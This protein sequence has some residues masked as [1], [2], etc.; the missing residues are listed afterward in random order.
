[1]P[2]NF[3]PISILTTVCCLTLCLA[4][5]AA[6]IAW[7]AFSS[8]RRQNAVIAAWE[9]LAVR[10]R[11]KLERIGLAK[12]PLFSG[13]Y[14]NRQLILNYGM[15][16][17]P[18]DSNSRRL[19]TTIQLEVNVPGSNWLSVRKLGLAE[20]VTKALSVQATPTGEADFDRQFLVVSQPKE[21]AMQLLGSDP[22]ARTILASLNSEPFGVTLY[23]QS[24]SYKEEG[25]IIDT[26]RLEWLFGRMSDLADR[27][28]KKS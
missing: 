15:P 21:I 10:N 27:F 7:I 19:Y 3:D 28:T 1:M 9:P 14:R 12:R 20:K 25:V 2:E 8:Q 11:L 6:P 4:A 26:N 18:S 16:G 22:E 17:N 23:H 5:F 13:T 24:L